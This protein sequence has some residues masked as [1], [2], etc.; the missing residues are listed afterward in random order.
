M[1]GLRLQL[2]GGF[3]LLGAGGERI[4]L[5]TRKIEALL[6]CLALAP[7]GARSRE[8][9]ARWLWGEASAAS[10]GANL[11][12]ALS[13]LGKALPRGALMTEGRSVLLARERLRV[14][15]LEFLRDSV[16]ADPATLEKAVAL[17]SGDLLSGLDIGEPDF[18]EWLVGEREQ[19]RERAIDVLARLAALHGA[20]GQADRAIQAAQ[21]L[22]AID[23]FEEIAHR[24]LMHLYAEQGRRGA[25][26]RQYQAC[27]AALRRELGAEPGAE[28]RAL[29]NDILRRQETGF[30]LA[31][32]QSLSAHE[33]PLTGR[34]DELGV[35]AGLLADLRASRGRLLAIIG[36][37]GIG[38][39][40]L[41]EELAALAAHAGVRVLVGRCY[42]SQ[43][44]FPFSPW[45]EMFRAAGVTQDRELLDGLEPAWRAELSVLV[46]ELAASGAGA[47]DDGALASRQW[48]M[49]EAIVR[50]LAAIAA[51]GP[52]LLVVEDLHWAD[53]MSLRLLAAAGRRVQGRAVGIVMT[54]RQEELATQPALG[55]SLQELDRTGALSRLRLAPLSKAETAAL[56]RALAR[57]GTRERASQDLVDRIWKASEGNPFVVLECMHA[58]GGDAAGSSSAMMP[59]RVRDMIHGHIARL[60]APARQLLATAAVA[61]RE[62]AFPLLQRASGLA[63]GEAS[64]ALEE[65]VR[66][67]IVHAV[68][69]HFDFVHDR[70]RRVAHDA[71]LPPVRGAQHAALAGTLED[72]FAHDL[73]QVYDRIAYHYARTD[74]HDKA[75]TYLERFAE[76]A[77]RIGAHDRAIESLD[78][79]LGRVAQLP[80]PG[81]AR[82]RLELLMRKTRSLMLLGKLKDVVEALLPEQAVV[83]AAA[84]PRLAGAYYLRLGATFNYMGDRRRSSQHATRA[85][86]EATSCGDSATM[87][88]A[89]AVLA[90]DRFW[91]QPA[92][93]VQH[94]EQAV[95]LLGALSETWWLGQAYWILG[96][97][98]SYCGRFDAALD[99]EA[100]ARALADALGDRRLACTSSWASGFVNTLAGNW[101]AA[102]S[103]CRRG[104]E[105]A[106]D[107]LS[108]MTAAG[109]LALAH[110]ERREPEIAIPILEET[111]PQAERFRFAPLHGLY[112]GFR[113]EAALQMGDVKA[114]LDYARRGAE[115]TRASDYLYGLGW[116]QRI[117]ARIARASDDVAL[118]RSRYEEA[119]ATF[120]GMGAPYEVARTRLELAGLVAPVAPG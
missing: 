7:Q 3:E 42:E 88:K 95:A 109:M 67:Q 30:A 51:R 112:L 58:L 118:A 19:M 48:R 84:D 61:G 45:V 68:G 18:E 79:A 97:N 74:R 8:E 22:L 10:A 113:G 50:L 98:L 100:R 93:G 90:N 82:R 52:L 72:L 1:A 110:V 86:E 6:A 96:L 92:L 59:E 119:I 2:F 105:S 47:P 117:L 39:T 116:T 99:A 53:D 71:L 62:F 21:R 104:V 80:A 115:I 70:I 108:R 37:A 111:I 76:R 34:D 16:S 78:E 5:R 83:D 4:R 41:T 56:T 32:P 107:P 12:Q 46:P 54:A 85:L 101:D 29:Y 13:L 44:Q 36:E 35:V 66:R 43:Q 26:L 89:H 55:A 9:L 11:R 27:V 64:E 38:K 91:A 57:P 81:R 77:A 28:T 65:L 87:G 14:D 23:P 120:E 49:S 24:M 33:S 103:E 94:G 106:P 69:E 102:V 20:A 73:P 40:R 15:A 75:V 25:A 63:E 60:G 114:A 17:Y 31:L